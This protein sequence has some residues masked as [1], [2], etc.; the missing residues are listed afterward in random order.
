MSIVLVQ[1]GIREFDGFRVEVTDSVSEYVTL[2]R[3]LFDFGALR[4]LIATG[5]PIRID[6]LH[7]GMNGKN[8]AKEVARAGCV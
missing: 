5:F 4:S 3:E 2:M 1:A 7:G 8:N 6:C